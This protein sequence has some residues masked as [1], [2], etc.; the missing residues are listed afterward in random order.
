MVSIHQ[1]FGIF[2]TIATFA[3]AVVSMSSSPVQAQRVPLRALSALEQ[4]GPTI[5]V[6]KSLLQ[7]ERDAIARGGPGRDVSVIVRFEGEAL[8]SYR[9]SIAGMPATDPKATG[10]RRLDAR[11]ANSQ[12]YLAYLGSRHQ[13]FETHLRGSIPTARVSHSFRAAVNAMA[14]VVPESRISSLIALPGVAA[15]YED[16]LLQLTTDT[17]PTFIGAPTLWNKLGGQGSAGEGVIVGV[18]DTGIWPEHPSLADPDPSGKAYA[19]P[20]GAARACE[21]GIGTNPGPAFSCNNKLIGAQ[22]FMRTYDAVVGLATTAYTSVRDDEGHGSHT[23]TTAAGN[24]SVPASIFGAPLGIVSGIAPRAQVMAYK[25]CGE[26]GCF[27]SD[28]VAAVNQAILD[29]VDVINFSI[30]GGA[31]PYADPVSLAFL[32]AYEAGIFVAASAG[33]SGPTPNTVDH[34]E[35]WTTTVAASSSNRQ[36]ESVLT[37]LSDNGQSIVL[38]GA[39]VTPALSTAAPVVVPATDLLC[40]SPFAAGSV[41]GKVVV[42]Q[43][44][45][46]ARVE[47]S[48]N[49]L[50]GGAVGMILYNPSLQGLG[51]DNHFIPS[52]HLEND[53]GAQLT[54]FLAGHTGVTATLSAGARTS[55]Q[56]DV[57]AAFSSRGGTLVSGGISKPDVTAPG[58]QILAGHTPTPSTSAGG[59][60]GQLFQA[61]QGTSMSSPHVAGAAA[62][63]KAV[64]PTWSPGQIRSALMTTATADVVKEDGVTPADS[65]DMGSGRIDLTRAGDPGLLFDETA[66]NFVAL[67]SSLW[68]ANYPSLYVPNFLGKIQVERTVQSTRNATRTWKVTVDAPSDLKV[69]AP[70]EIVVPAMRHARLP[71]SIDGSA[72]PIGETRHA[73]IELQ[74]SKEAT[75]RFPIT[76]VR[77]T[78]PVPMTKTCTPTDI[79][80]KAKINCTIVIS[81][82]TFEP[83]TVSLSDNLPNEL[84]LVKGS[85]VNATQREDGL[86]FSGTLAA[87]QPATADIGLGTSPKGYLPLSLF[88]IAPINGVGDET[89]TNFNVPAFTYGGATYTR[90][91]LVSNGYLVVGG[92]SGAD[93]DF[94]N[95]NLPDTAAPNNVLAP[96]WTDLNPSAGGAMRVGKL[97]DGVNTWLIADWENVPEFSTRK[98]ASFQVW[99]GLGATQDISFTYGSIQG[100]G[101]AGFLTVGAENLRGN[102]G[103]NYYFNG[104][105]TLPVAGTELRVTS[106]PG[107]PGESRTIRFSATGNSKGAWTDCALMASNTYF[108]TQT[109][110]V[111]GSVK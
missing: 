27:S 26:Q 62:L 81:N 13:E 34:R 48:Y 110:C 25:V 101:D 89:I 86:R 2:S 9:G 42:C 105:G 95:Q 41:A 91:G 54:D 68:E 67:Q 96:F 103:S 78:A 87:A 76:V 83:A 92:G 73:V 6:S 19:P 5:N 29:D 66:A 85:V 82:T 45:I 11:S 49:A 51:T 70:H 61:I 58:V 98:L 69:V 56:G 53:A 7:L 18:I 52:V 106:V 3:L 93:V 77:G 17:S 63:I 59:V 31:S 4:S 43:R 90:I 38:R 111:S 35:P 16:K 88:G 107:T 65:F 32:D 100:N 15:V 23:A 36:F 84:Q 102:R 50:Q 72:I 108:G 33:N 44:G 71:I 57:M 75:L 64:H 40:Q 12:R 28:S 97:T 60:P 99:I 8:S 47:K 30:S 14:V 10:E 20:P 94:A 46:N 37:L 39:S 1:R 80:K 74:R 104:T 79:A 21:F 109:A 22:R 24:G 55:A